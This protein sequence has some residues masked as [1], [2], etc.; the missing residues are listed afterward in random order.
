MKILKIPKNR[1]VLGKDLDKIIDKVNALANITGSGG[2][3]VATT[4]GGTSIRGPNK[5]SIVHHRWVEVTI[6]GENPMTGDA[7]TCKS[8]VF[9]AQ[10][11]SAMSIYMHPNLDSASY[12]VGDIVLA[13]YIGNSWVAE[14]AGI[15]SAS[16]LYSAGDGISI[17]G[18]RVI[19]SDLDQCE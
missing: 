7:Q 2:I 8:G 15:S 10:G 9:S 18:A 16:G 3:S 4:K 12:A 6:R 14:Y 17:S 13:H 1:P 11:E 5:R 19:S